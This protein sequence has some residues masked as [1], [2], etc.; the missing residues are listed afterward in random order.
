VHEIFEEQVTVSQQMEM[1]QKRLQ[2]E[3]ELLFISLFDER[4]GKLVIIVTF[5]ALLE[6]IR[7]KRIRVAQECPFGEIRILRRGK[8]SDRRE[9]G[10]HAEQEGDFQHGHEKRKEQRQDDR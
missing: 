5:L 1:I 3:K 10:E 4:T 6:L 8:R 9:S 2:R 7:L